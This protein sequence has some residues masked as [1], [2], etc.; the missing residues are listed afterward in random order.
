VSVGSIQEDDESYAKYT[1]GTISSNTK[2]SAVKVLGLNWNT[3]SDEF[4]FE[5]DELYDYAINLPLSKRSV[6][7]VTAKIFD[8]IGILTP[9]T[10]GMKILFQELCVQKHDW[11]GQL[12]SNLLNFTI[13]W[14]SY[15]C[16]LK[17]ARYSL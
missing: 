7:K 3:K 16:Q 17:V 8:P 12:Q 13:A 9:F 11:D 4:Y 5:Y 6:L 2:D 14:K 15:L 1:T 10:I